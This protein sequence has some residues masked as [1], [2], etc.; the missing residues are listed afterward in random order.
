VKPTITLYNPTLIHESGHGVI[1]R[2]LNIPIGQINTSVD[3]PTDTRLGTTS[4]IG[5]EALFKKWQKDGRPRSLDTAITALIMFMMA[6]SIAETE[7]IGEHIPFGDSGDG[8]EILKLAPLLSW[9]TGTIGRRLMRVRQLTHGLVRRHKISIL[10]VW[11]LL[12]RQPQVSGDEVD[13]ILNRL[14]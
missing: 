7:I 4:Y 3:D 13:E 1:G 11:N 10:C 2:V 12:L 8:A 6:G 14:R 5:H 9:Q